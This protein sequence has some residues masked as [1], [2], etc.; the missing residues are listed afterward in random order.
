MTQR[1]PSRI[2]QFQRDFFSKVDPVLGCTLL[3]DYLDSV[4]FFAK[5]KIG[6]FVKVSRA[7]LRMLGVADERD[8]IGKTDFDLF[9]HDIAQRYVDEDRRVM[10]SKIPAVNRVWLV[11]D[12]GGVLLWFL[13]T[14]IPLSDRRGRSIGVAGTLQDYGQA[15]AVLAP[16]ED[17]ASVVQHVERN[18]ASN[19]T[20]DR[21]AKV[22]HL[23][24]SQFIRRFRRVMHT[25]PGKYLNKVRMSHA[26]RALMQTD[27][28]IAR[29]ALDVGYRDHS[30]FTRRF[31]EQLGMTPTR[32]R[33]RFA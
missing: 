23:S 33:H 4:Q 9:E 8:V 12:S 5:N 21:L 31:V 7:N 28:S 30:Y 25:T 1:E 14:K 32:Y 13:C 22:A 20:V 3:F 6:E 2:R 18:H 27:Y 16:Y 29:I 11:P 15:G 17:L 26:C 24:V 10:A 19:L